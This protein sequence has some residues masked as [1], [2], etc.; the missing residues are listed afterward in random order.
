MDFLLFFVTLLGGSTAFWL[1][2]LGKAQMALVKVSDER[3]LR[4]A[5]QDEDKSYDRVITTLLAALKDEYQYLRWRAAWALGQIG[6]AQ[7]VT[8]LIAA[9]KDDDDPHV[10]ASAA[11]ALGQIGATQAITPLVA[12]LKN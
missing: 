12:A 4:D 9:L 2:H 10:R 7:A 3:S 11:Q 8:P 5:N 1:W 6:V